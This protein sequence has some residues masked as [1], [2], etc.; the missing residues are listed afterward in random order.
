MGC[1]NI[2]GNG[3]MLLTWLLVSS[4]TVLLLVFVFYVDE[5]KK[6]NA[7]FLQC[8]SQSPLTSK[9]L[10]MIPNSSP[11]LIYSFSPSLSLF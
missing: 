4:T 10:K 6:K 8:T 5:S 2:G 3:R 9:S 7:I 11:N 1:G